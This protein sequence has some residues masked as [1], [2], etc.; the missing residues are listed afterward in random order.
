MIKKRLIFKNRISNFLN[1]SKSKKNTKRVSL[2]NAGPLLML[3]TILVG[4]HSYQQADSLHGASPVDFKENSNFIGNSENRNQDTG[5]IADYLLEK[6][7]KKVEQSTGNEREQNNLNQTKTESST[8]T[9]K[10][11]Q[12]KGKIGYTVISQNAYREEDNSPRNIIVLGSLLT[13]AP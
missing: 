9:T 6:E 8:E 11:K 2:L 4:G 10:K 12:K 3:A 7:N 5:K 1:F 13:R